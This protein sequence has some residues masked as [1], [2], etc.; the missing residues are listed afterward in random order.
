MAMAVEG[1]EFEIVDVETG[2]RA[3]KVWQSSDMR[4]SSREQR[5]CN[6]AVH[7]LPIDRAAG[8]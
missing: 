4:L 3:N 6:A 2:G 7:H 8:T 5:L 1:G